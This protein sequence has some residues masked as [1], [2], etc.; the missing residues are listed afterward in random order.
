MYRLLPFLF[1]MAVVPD[2]EKKLETLSSFIGVTRDSVTSIKSGLDNF[3]STILPLVMA[4]A[5]K[6]AGKSGD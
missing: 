2:S 5:E 6:K 3:H 4:Q 1:M